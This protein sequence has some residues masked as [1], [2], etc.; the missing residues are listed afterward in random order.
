MEVV[1]GACFT[2]WLMSHSATRRYE[3]LGCCWFWLSTV[4]LVMS[5]N[6]HKSIAEQIEKQHQSGNANSLSLFHHRVKIQPH[7]V[8]GIISNLNCRQCAGT[9]V[10]TGNFILQFLF[11]HRSTEYYLPVNTLPRF[12]SS[13]LRR[14]LQFLSG[15]VHSSFWLAAL[16]LGESL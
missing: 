9:K 2:K 15:A 14:H 7:V 1:E 4:A 6:Q 13:R 12:S 10:P 3:S 5:T 8:L 11:K 16:R